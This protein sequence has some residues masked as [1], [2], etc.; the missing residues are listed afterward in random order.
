M[1]DSLTASCACCDPLCSY[2]D[3]FVIRWSFTTPD[4]FHDPSSIRFHS[5]PIDDD[6]IIAVARGTLWPVSINMIFSGRP[7]LLI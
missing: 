3:A 6:C 1:M 2:S 4:P 7:V 5:A